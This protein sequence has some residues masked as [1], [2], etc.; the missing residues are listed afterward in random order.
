VLSGQRSGWIREEGNEGVTPGIPGDEEISAAITAELE[1]L[2]VP[3]FAWDAV[4]R[5]AAR[6]TG[7]RTAWG[8]WWMGPVVAACLLGLAAMSAASTNTAWVQAFLGW[9][10]MSLEANSGGGVQA[11]DRHGFAYVVS[12]PRPVPGG[13]LATAAVGEPRAV[14]LAQA[15][16]DARTWGHFDVVAPTGVPAN[17]HLVK[18]LETSPF[19]GMNILFTY[20]V[21]DGD[22]FLIAESKATPIGQAS[23][24]HACP[25]LPRWQEGGT[26]V[27]IEVAHPGTLTPAQE[28][29]IQRAMRM[30]AF[31]GVH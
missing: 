23:C 16:H 25:D 18:I 22:T 30:A 7:K 29:H 12:P 24:P 9:H 11:V 2:D 27:F 10:V 21:A 20:R 3:P 19:G 31:V 4:R 5:R 14:T 13:G 17:A 28:D 1:E 15:Q 26:E 6:P 8:R